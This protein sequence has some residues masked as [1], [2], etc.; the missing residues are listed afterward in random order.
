MFAT[1]ISRDGDVVSALT[2]SN[3]PKRYPSQP[4]AH[5]PAGA[6]T[7]PGS[8]RRA[9]RNARHDTRIAADHRFYAVRAHPKHR[10]EKDRRPESPSHFVA[11]G[12]VKLH[13]VAFAET[14]RPF[15]NLAETYV[16]DPLIDE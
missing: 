11:I 12:L 13:G 10:L 14:G 7:R 8:P 5:P 2:L 4:V 15:Q 6:T 16:V 9:R 1:G 3:R